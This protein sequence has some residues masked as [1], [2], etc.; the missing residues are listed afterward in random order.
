MELFNEF[1]QSLAYIA[2]GILV[3]FCGKVVKD[4]LTPFND[5]HE[6]TTNDNPAL[7]LSVAGYYLSVMII[8]L[9]AALGPA[10]SPGAFLSDGEFYAS[11]GLQLLYT[12]CW[13][14]AG[15][16]ALNFARYIL[17]KFTLGHFSVET[18]IMRDRNLGAGAA[19][20]GSYIAS[21]LVIASA[22]YGETGGILTAAIFFVL[23]QLYLIGFTKLYQYMTPFNVH[24]QIEKGNNAA[25]IALAGNFI[26]MGLVV[27]AVSRIPFTGW[28]DVV[29]SFL[30]TLVIGTVFLVI[31]RQVADKI[32][33]PGKSL[34]DEIATDRNCAAALVEGA[35]VISFGALIFALV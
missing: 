22:I 24:D 32:L 29:G 13:S 27:A 2:L 30:V 3:F 33:L 19:E 1:F 16:F 12:A 4:F 35:A 8:Y 23:G 15:I 34:N 28:V 21:A 14:V 31:G 20:F 6:L 18:E 5:D 25:G 26:G 7:G 10:I 17:D 9:G 11:V